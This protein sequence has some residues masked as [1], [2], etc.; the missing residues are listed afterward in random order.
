MTAKM[1]FNHDT[2]WFWLI[3]REVTMT[4]IHENNPTVMLDVSFGNLD[5]ITV[6][7]KRLLGCHFKITTTLESRNIFDAAPTPYLKS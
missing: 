2:A 4:T 3:I 7:M 1:R 5:D 6:S